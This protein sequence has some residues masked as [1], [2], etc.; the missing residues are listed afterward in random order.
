MAY[1][2]FTQ[3]SQLEDKFGIQQKLTR[4]FDIVAPLE[5][6]DLLK[7]ELQ[8]SFSLPLLTEKA[9][10]ELLIAPIFKELRRHNHFTISFYSGY[11]FDVQPENGLTGYCDYLFTTETQSI[12]IKAPVFC[13]VEAK[14]R[15]VE[16][17]IA[18][19]GASMIAAKIFNDRKQ[20]PTEAIFGCVTTA[21]EWIFL[22]LDNNI[23]EI[24]ITKRYSLEEHSLPYLLGALQAIVQQFHS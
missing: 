7:N 18:Q 5:P 16:E 23:L 21:Y 12:D 20:R 15:S 1:S 17:G 6:S 9:K 10:S 8:E 2:D 24:D 13:I 11:L 4:I 14:N 3:V 22:K 19:A